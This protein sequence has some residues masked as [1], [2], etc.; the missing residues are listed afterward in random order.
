MSKEESSGSGDSK[1]L[2]GCCFGRQNNRFQKT[3]TVNLFQTQENPLQVR[4]KRE[5]FV[6]RDG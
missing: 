6:R 1:Q 3:W 4:N 5:Q 2:G